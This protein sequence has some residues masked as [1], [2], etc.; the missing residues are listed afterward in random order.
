MLSY[1]AFLLAIE[2]TYFVV[3]LCCV[4]VCAC[5]CEC[6]LCECDLSVVCIRADVIR[7]QA[8]KL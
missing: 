2:L 3:S 1:V 8:I 4:C 6:F 5:V 7:Y